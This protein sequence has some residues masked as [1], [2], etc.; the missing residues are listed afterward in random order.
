MGTAYPVDFELLAVS[1]LCYWHCSSIGKS[2]LA[3][4]Q[5]CVRLL[6][7]FLLLESGFGSLSLPVRGDQA[8]HVLHRVLVDSAMIGR[9]SRLYIYLLPIPAFKTTVLLLPILRSASLYKGL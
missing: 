9:S 3:N 6:R 4:L 8:S 1:L 5:H 7:F 2:R